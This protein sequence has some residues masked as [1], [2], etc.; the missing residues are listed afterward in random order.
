MKLMRNL[1]VLLFFSLLGINVLAQESENRAAAQMLVEKIEALTEQTDAAL[2]FSDLLN[3]VEELILHPVDVNSADPDELS[4]LFFLNE[5]Q[6]NNI[7]AYV[8]Q[9]GEIVSKYE[10]QAVDGV[11]AEEAELI[12]HFIVFTHEEYNPSLK[13]V[14]RYGRHRLMMRMQ[15]VLEDQ[16]GYAEASDSLRQA[17]PSRYYEGDPN[18]LYMRYKFSYPGKFQA[19]IVADKD[20]GEPFFSKNNEYGFDFYSAHLFLED[21]WVLKSAV[22]GDYHLRFGQGLTMWSGLA[23]GK[24][25]DATGVYR[26]AKE[27]SPNNSVNEYSFLR[28]AAASVGLG[29]FTITG[30][31]S[32]RDLDASVL[33]EDTLDFSEASTVYET[34]LHRTLTEISKKGQLNMQVYGGRISFSSGRFSLGVSGYKTQFDK[35]I[36]P[37]DNVYKYYDFRGTENTNAGV[38]FRWVFNKWILFGEGASSKNGAKAMLMGIQAMPIDEIGFSLLYRHYDKD[39]QNFFS[40]AFGDRDGNRNEEGLYAGIRADIAAGWQLLAYTDVVRF[41]FFRYRVDAPSKSH[42]YLLQLNYVPNSRL[43]MYVKFREKENQ[44][45]QAFDEEYFYQVDPVLQRNYRL[46]ASYQVTDQIELK[47]RVEYVTYKKAGNAQ[48]DGFLAYQDFVWRSNSLPLNFY[49]RY[50]IFDTYSWDERLYAYENDV[51]YAFSIPAYYDKGNRYYL[52]IK[53][54]AAEWLDCWVRFSQTIFFDKESIGTGTDEI[55]SNHKSE[56]KVQLRMK[57]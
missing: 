21:T 38:D 55:D 29:K 33:Q 3:T 15:R 30:F 46:H 17:Y 32:T 50:A 18:R 22:V 41:P 52:M 25:A 37:S 39:Y 5:L 54:D 36:N 57:F 13:Q 35:D 56:L 23:F 40:N 49:A 53:W 6:I 7:I 27:L 47:S 19:G 11:N 20:A 12:S 48:H 4:R 28:G 34:G 1:Y 9:N 43:N 2:D 45:N 24:S 51:L 16:A 8:H 42:D 26:R 10:L 14:A 44:L 31:Y